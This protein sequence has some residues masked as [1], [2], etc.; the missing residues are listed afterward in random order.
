VGSLQVGYKLLK[1][2]SDYDI[3]SS[4]IKFDIEAAVETA[5]ILNDPEALE[6]LRQSMKEFNE[7]G[8]LDWEQVKK[9]LDLL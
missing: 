8:G 6:A 1:R 5:D 2:N 7:G 3:Y 4:N 9:E